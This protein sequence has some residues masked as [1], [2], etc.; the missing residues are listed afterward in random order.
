MSEYYEEIK[1]DSGGVLVNCTDEIQSLKQQLKDAEKKND[2]N[3]SKRCELENQLNQAEKVIN[4]YADHRM[5]LGKA[6]VNDCYDPYESENSYS[7][8]RCIGKR[9]REYKAKYSN[10]AK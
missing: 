8:E 9:A 7:N 1:T 5:M 2:I 6:S 4:F 3:F 10:E